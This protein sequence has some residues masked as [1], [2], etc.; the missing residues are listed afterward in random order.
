MKFIPVIL[1]LF[2]LSPKTSANEVKIL[3][4]QFSQNQSG[5][6]S[7][8]VTLRHHD[9]SWKHY[10]DDWRVVDKKGNVLADRVL[11]HPHIHE[12]PF[13]RGL[14]NV[15]IPENIKIVF[16]EAHD[17]VHG[18]TKTILRINLMANKD[19]KLNVKAK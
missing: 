3:R 6:W 15:K 17:K 9:T 18:W 1:L 2:I 14:N 13:T 8:K 5:L 7:I 12:Q 10:A 16:I 4:A 11:V 19:G